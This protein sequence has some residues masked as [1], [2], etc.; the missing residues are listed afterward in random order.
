MTEFPWWKRGVI[1]QIYPLSYQ[2]SSGSG[3]GDFEGIIQRLDYVAELGVDAIWMSPFYPSPMADFGY[4]VANYTGIDSMF[5]NMATFDRLLAE[6]HKREL[7]LII[8]F[9]P[10][11]SSDE[12]P[13]FIESKKSK[14]NPK[15]DW[16]IWRDPKPDGSPP[17]NWLSMFG[18]PAWNLDKTT[19]QYYLH[20]FLA[21]QPDINWRNPA[22]KAAMLDVLRFWLKKGVDGFRL[23]AVPF[24]G[25]DPEFKDNPP[26]DNPSLQDEYATTSQK[27]VNME[28]HDDLFMWYKEMR[29]VIEE[30]DGERFLVGE[31]WGD[32]KLW[33]RN[34]GENGEGLHLPYNFRLINTDWNASAVKKSV[35]DIEDVVPEF[36]WPNYVL[37]NHDVLR[38][39]SRI[40][41]EQARVAAFLLLTLRG[42]PTIYYGDELGLPNGDIPLGKERDPAANPNSFVTINRDVARTPMQWSANQHAGFTRG[43]GPWLPVT[44]DYKTRNVAVMS[45]EPNSILNLYRRLLR[46]RKQSEALQIGSYSPQE[47][48][49]GVYAYVREHERERMLVALNFTGEEKTV[50]LPIEGKVIVNTNLDSDSDHVKGQMKLRPNEAVIVELRPGI[51][52][53]KDEAATPLE[54]PGYVLVVDDDLSA[55][56]LLSRI[57]SRG[58]V[59]V[60]TADDGVEA[61]DLA[62]EETP[63]LILLDIMMPRLDG[64]EVVLRLQA[65]P[66]LRSVP[67]VAVTASDEKKKREASMLPGIKGVL[68]KAQE[69]LVDEVERFVQEFTKKDKPAS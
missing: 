18:G 39:A 17:N 22:T 47:A 14:E 66:K 20:T 61:L 68:A 58:G 21:K 49:E 1:Y 7:K 26:N 2:D 48:P 37:A 23:D 65:D 4:D 50:K 5:G 28:Y 55:R 34:Y 25:K 64:F 27:R 69:D 38:L 63:L 62:Y 9:V 31:V 11:H 10:N 6:I 30:F 60:K 53:I 35:E 40:G 12:H 59:R 16:Y 19:G 24:I 52:D 56:T 33:A 67:V 43:K 51:P 32:L 42:T 13:W 45:E 44:L 15:R 41:Q 3:M 54:Q 46:V 29:S 8:D 36:G 57:V